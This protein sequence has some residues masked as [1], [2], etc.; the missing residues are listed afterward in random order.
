M[1]TKSG[2]NE[3]HGD[4]FE[5]VRNGKFNARNVF[6]TKRDTLKRNQFGGT[7]GGAIISNKLF[8]FAGYQGTT[9][10][11]DPSATQSFI[12]TPAIL[13]GD[14]TAFASPACNAGVQRTLR[15]PYVT[16]GSSPNGT[17][18]TIS[19]AQYNRVALAIVGRSDFPKTSDPCGRITWGNPISVNDH[20]AV[21]RIDYQWTSKHTLFGRYLLDSSKGPDPYSLT[22]NL[23]SVS[24]NGVNGMA[25]AFTLGSTYLIRP[26]M[27]NALR[28]TANRTSTLNE[29]GEFYAWPELGANIYSPYPKRS[30]LSV[31]GA[32]NVG[33]AAQGGPASS[34]LLGGNDDVSWSLG[35]HQIA[36]GV[37][38]GRFTNVDFNKGRD[39]GRAAISGQT[40]GLG[41]S[42]F[43]LGNVSMFD[44][45]GKNRRDEFKWYLGAYGAD[46]W[47]AA[48]KLTVNYGLRWEPYFPQTFMNGD[49]MNFDLDAYMK[50]AHTSVY[51]NAPP[52][53]FFT[54]DAG[55]PGRAAMFTKWWNVSPRLGLAW[56]VRGDGRTSVRASYG[57]FYDFV[58]LAFYTGRTPAFLPFAATTGV[59]IDNPWAPFPGGNPFP[60]TVPAPGQ[61]G[62]FLARQIIPSIPYHA[63]PPQVSQ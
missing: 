61:E 53:L 15:A 51:K 63:Q 25:N 30:V 6:A 49:S 3:W 43:F 21:G 18:Y 16:G 28:L 60:F 20:M 54:G 46:T 4:L 59:K 10:R 5:F 23:L 2:T 24:G 42:D 11:Q 13:A 32:F 36:F 29:S 38:G 26:N 33:S 34:N 44:Q 52:G 58:P 47:K 39:T 55:N 1:V 12:P 19:P 41:M 45:A 17:I 8:F 62:K 9:T 57:L 48:S 31:T 35:N 14:W 27:V 50:G 40:T 37:S 7:V 56:D 22:G